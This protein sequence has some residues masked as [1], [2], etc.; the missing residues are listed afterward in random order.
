M[1]EN[2]DKDTEIGSF[3]VTDADAGQTHTFTLV[4]D[5]GGKFKLD[6]T[7]KLLTATAERLEITEIHFIVVRATDNGSPPKSVR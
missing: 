2:A 3:S 1:A 7:G 5:N 6:A 4:D